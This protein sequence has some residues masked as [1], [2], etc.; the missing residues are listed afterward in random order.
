MENQKLPQIVDIT[1]QKET[2][3]DHKEMQN[4]QK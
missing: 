4:D 2:Q 3:K 1:Y